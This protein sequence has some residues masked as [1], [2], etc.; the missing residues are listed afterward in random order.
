M[1][2]RLPEDGYPG[3]DTA[4]VSF[5]ISGTGPELSEGSLTVHPNPFRE[6][7]TLELDH[8][9]SNSAVIEIFDQSGRIMMRTERELLPGRNIVPVDCRRLAAGVYSLRLTTGGGNTTVRIV[10]Q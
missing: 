3:N 2:N 8:P 4:M 10:K 6:S 1:I 7:I 9:G 5:V